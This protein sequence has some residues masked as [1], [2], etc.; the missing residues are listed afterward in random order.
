MV[1]FRLAPAILRNP[2]STNV[3]G[4]SG[5]A[6]LAQ[7]LTLRAIPECGRSLRLQS[8]LAPTR[9]RQE[10]GV[11]L[12][13]RRVRNVNARGRGNRLP[14]RYPPPLLATNSESL[15]EGPVAELPDTGTRGGSIGT[16]RG[17]VR[18]AGDEAA[19]S[20]WVPDR[21]SPQRAGRFRWPKPLMRLVPGK[22]RGK[23]GTAT[24]EETAHHE[25]TDTRAPCESR[26]LCRHHNVSLCAAIQ[27]EP[28]PL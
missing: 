1:A 12:L 25:E 27:L 3:V 15:V 19:R 20:R 8:V 28:P 16:E 18:A 13:H 5:K 26:K 21:R 7:R 4:A 17:L 11:V 6:L 14:G 9:L 23:H 2:P 10:I 24:R 22:R